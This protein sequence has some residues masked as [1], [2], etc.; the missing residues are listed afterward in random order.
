MRDASVPIVLISPVFSNYRCI[1][2]SL[3]GHEMLVANGP[4]E[5]LQLAYSVEKLI[6]V[7]ILTIFSQLNQSNSLYLLGMDFAEMP[8]FL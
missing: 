8:K 7:G 6:S 5:Y 1:N 2:Q 4:S 3:L